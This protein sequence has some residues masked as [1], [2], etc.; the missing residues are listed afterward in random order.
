MCIKACIAKSTE[1]YEFPDL[2]RVAESWKHNLAELL[3]TAGLKPELERQR[4]ID[5]QFEAN[6]LT[7]KDW[8]VDSRYEKKTQQEAESIFTAATEAAHGVLQWLGV[9]W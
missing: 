8:S 3:N 6:W 2:R 7:V 9:Y 1:E 4:K 5:Q